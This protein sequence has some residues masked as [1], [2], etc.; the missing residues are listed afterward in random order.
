MKK[1]H[2]HR[3]WQLFVVIALMAVSSGSTCG[4]RLLMSRRNPRQGFLRSVFLNQNH[5]GHHSGT[6]NSVLPERGASGNAHGSPAIAPFRLVFHILSSAFI[7]LP[8][9]NSAP[10]FEIAT[11]V[12]GRAPPAIA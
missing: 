10:A 2:I 12:L 3:Y 8:S 4:F 1:N 9:D 6:G 5:A 11:T 7:A